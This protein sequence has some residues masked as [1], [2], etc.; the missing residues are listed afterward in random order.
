MQWFIVLLDLVSDM[1]LP[2][3]SSL[4]PPQDQIRICVVEAFNSNSLAYMCVRPS[5]HT[6]VCRA[7]SSACLRAPSTCACSA[8][9]LN[10]PRDPLYPRTGD[11]RMTAPSHATHADNPFTVLCGVPGCSCSRTAPATFQ[12]LPRQSSGN[13]VDRRALSPDPRRGQDPSRPHAAP[14]AS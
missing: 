11:A 9:N 5:I 12:H 3:D 1:R 6:H 7:S 10:P 2:E 8:L 4:P 13:S 14:T